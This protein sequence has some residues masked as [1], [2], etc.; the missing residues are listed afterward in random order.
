MS[1]IHYII[2]ASG[3]G[4][5]SIMIELR[6]KINADFPVLFAHRYITRPTELGGENYVSL[7]EEEFQLRQH[8]GLFAMHWSSNKFLYGIGSEI[9]E[10]LQMGFEVV[11][12]GSREYLPIASRYYPSLQIYHIQVDPEILFERLVKRG[13]ETKEEI[14][15]RMKKVDA[16]KVEHPNLHN[17]YNNANL[18]V[19][20]QEIYNCMLPSKAT[21]IV[22]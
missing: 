1:N 14:S 11:V 8:A 12:N 17:I 3:A 15:N 5:D 7:T 2:G 4:K 20:V 19:A 9:N 13:R 10:W 16:F 21:S 22:N 18:Q 6:K